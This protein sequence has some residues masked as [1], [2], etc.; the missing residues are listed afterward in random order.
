[1]DLGSFGFPGA[2]RD[3]QELFDRPASVDIRTRG[4]VFTGRVWNIEHERFEYNSSLVERDFLA[5]TGAVAVVVL[6]E[7]DNLLVI[8]QY[9][10]PVRMREWEIPAGLLDIDGEDPAEAAARELA[11]EVDL[12]AAQWNVL[13]DYCTSPGGSNEIVRIFL[14]RDLSPAHQVHERV[15]E[16]ADMDLRWVTLDHAHEAAIRGHVNNSIFRVAVLTAH[17][18]RARGW[19][20]LKPVNAP[21]PMRDWRDA[22]RLQPE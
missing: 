1:M 7:E 15:D 8:R 14:A 17:A 22:N 3:D 18:S 12:V 9:R 5:H 11:E 10:H 4:V 2:D 6:D 16:E 19:D 21:W 20:T 13:T